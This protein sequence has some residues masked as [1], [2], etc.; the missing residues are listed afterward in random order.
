MMI[1]KMKSKILNLS[2]NDKIILENTILAFI[3][4]G[5]AL[6]VTLFTLPVYIKFFKEDIILGLWYTLL[7][8]LNWVLNFD[9]GIG[10]GLRNYLS[11]SIAKKDEQKTK[12]Y[13][14]SA[15]FSVGFIAVFVSLVFFILARFINW[16][17]V[18]NI[19]E[20]YIKK[21]DL[22]TAIIIVFIGVM[23]HFWL[24]LINSILYALQKSSLNNL[25]ILITNVIILFGTLLLPSRSNSINIINMSIL[26]AIA[27]AFPLIVS[28]LI[29]FS[30][31]L[32]YARPNLNFV[33]RDGIKDI[34]SLGGTFFFIQIAYMIIMS[35]NEFLISRLFD[36][37]YVVN[38]Q[39]YYRIFSLGST[40]FMLA[41]T[42]L[43]S[44]I[45][46]ANVEKNYE[47]IKNIYKRFLLLAVLFC[48]GEFIVILFFRDI[49]IIWLGKNNVIHTQLIECITF[50][51]FGCLMILSSLFSSIANGLGTLA[52]QFIT[53]MIGALLKV[54]L[55]FILAKF[56]SS[57]IVIMW[58]NILCILIYCVMQP[59]FLRKYL[60]KRIN[61][62]KSNLNGRK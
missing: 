61:K 57:W 2:N 59:I 13:I 17:K 26:H 7:S 43:W 34:L 41:L 14:S 31:K 52:P 20:Y 32:S 56:Y 4:K 36:I 18:L 8:L 27:V 39:I 29:I 51:I 1:S 10:N 12:I 3:V 45:T 53:F 42:P 24:K 6:F 49:L 48:M 62:C 54:P 33:K 44:V 5:G 16:N 47:W 28:S 55:T 15:Y 30:R 38:Y 37:K 40:V 25:L 23:L 11:A 9:L 22:V 21:E 50:S 19:S 46:K 60:D 58:A 35:S